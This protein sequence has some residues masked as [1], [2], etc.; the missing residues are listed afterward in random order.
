MNVRQVICAVKTLIDANSNI[1]RLPNNPFSDSL[2]QHLLNKIEK[3]EICSQTSKGN[4]FTYNSPNQIYRNCPMNGRQLEPIRAQGSAYV[5]KP[6]R[7]N[8][9]SYRS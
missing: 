9:G 2:I 1:T 8:K 7:N 4:C 6:Q 3:L 5:Y